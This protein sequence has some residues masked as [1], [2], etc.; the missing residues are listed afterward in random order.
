[1]LTASQAV[2]QMNLARRTHAGCFRQHISLV[3][4]KLITKSTP[5]HERM[6]ASFL[7]MNSL[8]FWH[9]LVSGEIHGI[10]RVLS[11]VL[12]ISSCN[13][14][15]PP[16]EVGSGILPILWMEKLSLGDGKGLAQS[17]TA[18]WC[19]PHTSERKPG[20]VASWCSLRGGKDHILQVPMGLG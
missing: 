6:C 1:M 15:T 2:P 5:L 19:E 17:H 9:H 4:Q 12:G 16:C 18:R 11:V 13:L 20:S 8:L 14:T 10:S 3:V 7:K